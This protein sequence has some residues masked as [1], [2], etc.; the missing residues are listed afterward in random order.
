MLTSSM[1]ARTRRRV[2]K[3][4]AS[5][6][7]YAMQITWNERNITHVFLIRIILWT[8]YADTHPSVR[9][10]AR[11]N[12]ISR[13][14]HTRKLRFPGSIKRAQLISLQKCIKFLAYTNKMY[15]FCFLWLREVHPWCVLKTSFF[16][17]WLKWIHINF[18]LYR[19]WVNV[20]SLSVNRNYNLRQI[21]AH[22]LMLCLHFTLFRCIIHFLVDLHSWSA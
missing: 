2:R 5:L 18:L 3:G 22:V 9:A 21:L 17:L 4:M 8:E 19:K 7:L 12:T 1:V 10:A 16:K 15:H 11:T 14:T 6:Q 20:E 13:P